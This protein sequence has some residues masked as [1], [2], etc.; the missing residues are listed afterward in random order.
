MHAND[1]SVLIQPDPS[2]TPEQVVAIQLD[3]LKRNDE[4]HRDAGIA[5]NWLF[6]HPLN[7]RETGPYSRFAAMLRSPA[8][9]AML[10]HQDHRIE[11]A[12][13]SSHAVTFMVLI[14]TLS[15][16]ALGYQWTVEK[17]REGRRTACWMTTGV[18]PPIML[19]EFI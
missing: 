4:P 17:V 1:E 6:A 18:S 19:G 5:Q 15:G 14:K 12:R 3:A 10:D 11:I 7:K 8:F 16:D 13:E 2:L 9:G